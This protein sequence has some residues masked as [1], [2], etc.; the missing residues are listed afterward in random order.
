MMLGTG[1]ARS[2]LMG[3]G[4]LVGLCTAPAQVRLGAD[5]DRIA[6]QA[7]VNS[8]VLPKPRSISIGIAGAD[9]L[10]FKVSVDSAGVGGTNFIVV[11]PSSG[12]APTAV[13]V[14]LNPNVVPY[15]RPGLYT[16]ILVFT[17][18]GQPCPPA[19]ASTVVSLRWSSSPPPGITAVVN[20]ATLDP[21]ISPGAM[22]SI[23][24]TNLSTPPITAEYNDAGLYP[25]TLGN[26]TVTFNGIAAPLLFVS[27]GQINAVVPYAVAGQ[28]TVEVVVTHYERGAPFTVPLA[29]TSPGIFAASQ[30]T[31]RPGPILNADSTPNNA[32]NPAQKGSPIQIFATGAGVWTFPL[33]PG[34]LPQD[35]VDGSVYLG[36]PLVT[37]PRPAAPVSLT[38]GGQAARF[39]YMGPAPYQVF[40][41]L[42]INAVVPDGIESGAQPVVLTIGENNNAQQQI[43]VAVQ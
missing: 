5:P 10:E 16:L 35:L 3:C 13:Q 11:S 30:T 32:E 12:V 27:T 22:A 2:F 28:K 42:Q 24:G 31:G 4:L 19:C 38:I 15:L 33:A 8:F 7:T 6:F 29:D 14:G 20:A 43:T 1:L 34:M 26:T 17:V 36:Y 23:L 25:T 21:S 39:Q 18:P 40:G 41:M 37:P 9:K